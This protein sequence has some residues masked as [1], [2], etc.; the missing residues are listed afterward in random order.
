MHDFI[1]Y[2]AFIDFGKELMVAFVHDHNVLYTKKND[3]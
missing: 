3:P 2:A 1:L